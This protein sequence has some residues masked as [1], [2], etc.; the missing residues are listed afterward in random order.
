MLKPRLTPRDLSRFKGALQKAIGRFL[1]GYR[2]VAGPIPEPGAAYTLPLLYR[3]RPLGHLSLISEEGAA[4]LSKELE[5]L[6]PKIAASALDMASLHKALATDRETGLMNRER[7]LGIVAKSMGTERGVQRS[8]RSFDADAE[9]QLVLALAQASGKPGH[10]PSLAEVAEA[11]GSIEELAAL[12]RLG[13]HRLGALFRSGPMEA[14]AALESARAQILG[15]FPSGGYLSAYA[16]FPQDLSFE[17]GARQKSRKEL[18]G[19]LMERADT[20]LHFGA[21]R[22]GPAPVIGFGELVAS[23]GQVV[24]VLPQ[25][26]VVINLGGPMGAIPGQVFAVTSETGE[27]KGE[28]T[29]FETGE[30][31]SL[32]HVTGG[33]GARLTGGDRLAFSRMDWSLEPGDEMEAKAGFEREGFTKNLSRLSDTGRPL[34][35]ALVRLDDHERLAAVAGQEEI[36]K[37]LDSLMTAALALDREAPEIL[38][39]WGPGTLALAWTEIAPQTAKSRAEA[40]VASLK[41]RAP[42]SAGLVHWP[43]KA[44]KPEALLAAAQKTLVEAAMTGPETVVEFGPQTLNISGDHRFDEGDLEGALEEYFKGLSMDPPLPGRLNLLNSLGVC[45]GRLGDQAA[46]MAAFEEVAKLDPENLMGHFNIGCSCLISGRLEEALEA[47]VRAEE[48]EPE[49]FQVLFNLGKTALELGDLQKA[50]AS[51]TKAAELKDRHGRVH[52]LLGKAKMLSGDRPGAL[53]AYKRAVK[54]NPDDSD[55]L[56]ALGALFLDSDNDQEV[57]LSLFQRSVELDPTNSLFRRRL[58]MLLYQLGDYDA[59]ERHLRLAMEYGCRED[60]VKRH[61]ASLAAGEPAEDEKGESEAA[62]PASPK[63]GEDT[64][65]SSSGESLA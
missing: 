24:Q 49:N 21:G 5:A 42:S 48:I 33:R 15:R 61:L 62:K 3:G 52:R 58:G 16:A 34:T 54:F 29:V 51:L 1:P 60:D 6:L 43:A 14:K 30:A 36:K 55:S 41:G 38:V 12:A 13:D 28:I 7:F 50:L 44:L 64:K 26:R 35:V 11:L 23:Y 65:S 31:Y 19:V 10:G 59:A 25:E 22:R 47:F 63:P 57:A 9:P 4:R 37:R 17:P 32:A 20:A 45:H 27:P 40:L 56:S 46:A 8:P 18:A 39:E 53:A 2:P